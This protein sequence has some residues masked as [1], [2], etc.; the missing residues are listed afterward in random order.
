MVRSRADTALLT[1]NP[2]HERA[3]TRLFNLRAIA[4]SPGSR[5]LRNAPAVL[6]RI[7]REDLATMSGRWRR[8]SRG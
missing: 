5:G 3:Y 6:M 7:D 4:R 8:G 1:V 2:K